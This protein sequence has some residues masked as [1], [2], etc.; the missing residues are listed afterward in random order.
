MKNRQEELVSALSRQDVSMVLGLMS[1]GIWPTRSLQETH[2][3]GK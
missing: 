2:S 1:E 3:P